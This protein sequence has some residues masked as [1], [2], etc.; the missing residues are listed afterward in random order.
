M[1]Y[2]PFLSIYGYLEK[3]LKKLVGR[4]DV[5]DALGRLDRLTQEEA[6][7]AAAQGLETTQGVND[8]LNVVMDGS[9]II[10]E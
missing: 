10:F 7:M 4:A 3:Y 6:L 2:E 8:K 1:W 5:E 9:Q